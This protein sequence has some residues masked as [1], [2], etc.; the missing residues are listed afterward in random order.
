MLGYSDSNK[1]GGYLTANWALYQAEVDLVE[2]AR[3]R[4]VRLRFFHGRGGTVGRGGGPSYDAVLAQPPGAVDGSL[5][6]TEQGE[7]IAAK[8][9]DPLM[10]RRNL[11]A[12]VAA[13]LE[14]SAG[15]AG[16][17]GEEGRYH[18]VMSEL[19]VTARRAYRHLV[20]ET[21]GFVD[22][23]RAATPIQEVAELNIGSRPASRKASTRIE[24]LRA[25]PWVFSWSQ[26]RIM[27][28]GWYGAGTAFER[29]LAGG[30]QEGLALLREMY[31][32]WP[33]FRTVLANMGMVLAKSD[34]GIAARYRDLVPD[35]ELRHAVFDAIAA[36][37]ARTLRALLAITGATSPL[38]D[39]PSLARSVRNRFPYL[40]PL[41]HLQVELLRRWR[42][43]DRGD[44]VKRAIHLSINGLATG[45][46]NSG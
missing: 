21:P 28:P 18:E 17:A 41:N 45:L 33:F 14:A 30:G 9:A 4:G 8:F 6:L 39:N 43:G 40:D 34:L 31:E 35:A 46:R 5:R 26:C 2:V 10:A 16:P 15:A 36:E 37:H 24:D 3:R 20:Y 27:L 23:F 44:Q 11:E 19:A 1:D 38:V 22:W 32:R 29:W 42:A 7:V 12:L 25:I 13:T